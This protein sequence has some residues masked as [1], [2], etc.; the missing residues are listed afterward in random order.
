[1]TSPDTLRECYKCGGPCT[2]GYEAARKVLVARLRQ[3]GREDRRNG[4]TDRANAVAAG[5]GVQIDSWIAMDLIAEA[6]AD[7][8]TAEKALE[9]G[10]E[11]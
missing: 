3:I 1:M 6:T 4:Y 11:G 2:C 8:A 10:R 7:R 9:W 5:E